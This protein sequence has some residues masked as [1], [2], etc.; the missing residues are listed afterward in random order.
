MDIF[1][2]LKEHELLELQ[3]D[4]RT[5]LMIKK[6]NNLQDLYNEEIEEIEYYKRLFKKIS[7]ELESI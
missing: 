3:E 6:N 7:N 4:F 1:T 2:N 5:I